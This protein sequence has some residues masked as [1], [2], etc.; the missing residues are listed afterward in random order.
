[1]SKVVWPLFG[2]LYAIA[3]AVAI[4]WL[5]RHEVARRAER[6]RRGGPGE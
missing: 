5:I 4:G 3:S 6:F 2:L 1:M